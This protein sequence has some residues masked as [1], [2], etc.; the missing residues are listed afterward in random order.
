MQYL[1]HSGIKQFPIL[2]LDDLG[3]Q[4]RSFE[5]RDFYFYST[6]KKDTLLEEIVHI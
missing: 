1:L 6:W 4:T 3:K 2:Q 5:H